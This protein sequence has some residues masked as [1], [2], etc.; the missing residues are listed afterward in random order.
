MAVPRHHPG[1]PTL[2]RSQMQTQV[3]V[4]HDPEFQAGISTPAV[5]PP[6]R[7]SAALRFGFRFAFSYF[8]L[9]CFPFPFGPL[10][11]T[12]K[13]AGWYEVAWQKVVPW[14]AQPW[15]R[16]AHPIAAYTNGSGE[17]TYDYIKAL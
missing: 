9:Y 14:V 6:A 16:P 8:V 7:W 17:T 2:R 3:E 11:Y 12:G 10:P 4:A 15:L 5:E 1:E 13:L